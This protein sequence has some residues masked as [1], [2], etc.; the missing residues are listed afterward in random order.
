[1]GMLCVIG[2]NEKVARVYNTRVKPGALEEGDLVKRAFEK[3]ED[4]DKLAATWED[5]YLIGHKIGHCTFKLATMEGEPVSKTWNSV[6]LRKYFSA[7]K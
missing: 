1:M 7:K 2:Q 5:S 3:I 6:H 4:H